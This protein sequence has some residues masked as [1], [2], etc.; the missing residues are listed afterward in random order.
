MINFFSRLS[1][2]WR[3]AGFVC[4]LLLLLI[5]SGYAGL[6]GMRNSNRSLSTVYKNQV[7]PLEKL[8]DI[9]NILQVDIR[10]TVDKILFEQTTWDKALLRL[11]QSQINLKQKWNEVLTVRDE[12]STPEERA[13][14]DAIRPLMAASN[15]MTTEIVTLVRAKDRGKLDEYTDAKLY[16]LVDGF[17]EKIDQ[18][19]TDRIT[20]IGDTYDEAQRRFEYSKKA[21][22]VTILV[23]LLVSLVASFFLI[24]NI[25]A[26]LSMIT[27]AMEKMMEGDLTTQ[28]KQER[29]DELGIL[30]AGFNQMTKYLSDL[31]AQI[32]L[33]GIQVTSSVTEIAATIKQQETMANEHAATTSEIAAST[34][35]IAATSSH[36]L[37]AMKAVTSLAKETA[38]SATGGHAGLSNIDKTMVRM[39]ELT[40]SIVTKLS[41]LN[42][43]ATNIAGM[44][45][46]INKVADQTNL[47]SL[48]AA[49]E[50]EK[51]GEYGA[52][53]A[54][55]ATEIRRLADQTAVATFDIEQMVQE[56][57]S[58]VSAGV[59][60]ID[61]FA[62]D[63]RRSVM[64]IRQSG[65]QLSSV[66]DQVQALIPQVESINEGIEAQS[67][68]AKQI[69]EAVSQLNDAA[70]QTAESVAQ[71]STTIFQLNRAA[72][73]LQDGVSQFKVEAGNAHAGSSL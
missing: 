26:P 56:V 5:G 11:E 12:E 47:L 50:A 42:E 48:N 71:T 3:L 49:I 30:V 22:V 10:E 43:K 53:F 64:E 24:R 31:V 69:S 6:D 14:L 65:N 17:K 44:V 13:W 20:T 66:I 1:I 21:F 39:E 37:D 61:K 32:Q 62:E 34:T 59:M 52:G 25:D 60:A 18:L 38:K 9:Q 8:R 41:I 54:V 58:A 51:A 27:R 28:L 45:K 35:Q 33:S 36:L 23:G 63:V 67:L 7:I 29:H 73:I 70:Q 72:L 46:T 4:F 68:G 55:V 40:G 19:V 2:K 16:P 57:Q 15:E